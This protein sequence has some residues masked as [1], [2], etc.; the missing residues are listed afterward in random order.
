M[1]QAEEVPTDSC[2]VRETS[3]A[4]ELAA[5]TGADPEVEF[6]ATTLPSTSEQ[7]SL[8]RTSQIESPACHRSQKTPDM[9]AR[10]PAPPG[11]CA[12]EWRSPVEH[13]GTLAQWFED[14]GQNTKA[15]RSLAAALSRLAVSHS[16]SGAPVSACEIPG[17]RLYIE[18]DLG[19][20]ASI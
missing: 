17:E 19:A 10:S 2:D 18:L 9:P 14:L 13:D 5:A 16:P 6:Q 11:P 1:G 12:A 8:G 3:T 20:Q 7:N 4:S 15:I